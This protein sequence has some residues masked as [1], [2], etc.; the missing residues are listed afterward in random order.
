MTRPADSGPATPARGGSRAALGLVGFVV[1]GVLAGCGSAPP[2]A[3]AGDAARA[4]VQLA[5][6]EHGRTLMIAKCGGCHRAPMPTDHRARDWPH[7]LDEMTDRAKLDP[8]Q[9]HL[10]E[11]YLVTMAM[12]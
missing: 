9:R 3:T 12:R 2:V 11:Q 5:D 7:S 8:T 1:A 10:I 6:L 4:N